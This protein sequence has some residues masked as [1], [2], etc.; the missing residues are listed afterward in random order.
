MSIMFTQVFIYRVVA[1]QRHKINDDL[2]ISEARMHPVPYVSYKLTY[3]S[4][5]Y[6]PRLNGLSF[7]KSAVF[8]QL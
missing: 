8:I 7:T 6:L 2:L 3:Q 1:V 4:R 5:S